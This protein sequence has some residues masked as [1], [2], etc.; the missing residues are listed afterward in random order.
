MYSYY[1]YIKPHVSVQAGMH[2]KCLV[3]P[4]GTLA[5][6]LFFGLTLLFG[7]VVMDRN[8]P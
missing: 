6:V 5:V 3:S 7:T 2:R 1:I 8:S 4:F